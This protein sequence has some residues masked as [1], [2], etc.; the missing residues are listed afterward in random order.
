MLHRRTTRHEWLLC[1]AIMVSIV[2]GS[3]LLTAQNRSASAP[4]KPS[5]SDTA[6]STSGAQVEEEVARLRS[7]LAEL[8]EAIRVATAKTVVAAATPLPA[9]TERANPATVVST[10][11]HAEAGRKATPGAADAETLSKLGEL[12]DRGAGAGVLREL[13]KFLTAGDKGRAILY[14]VLRFLDIERNRATALTGN[15]QLAFG[16]VHIAMLHPVELAEFVHYYLVAPEGDG[17]SFMRQKMYDFIPVF[18]RFH[19]GRFPDLES[20]F[21]GDLLARLNRRS[22]DLRRLF[23]AMNRLDI[24]PPIATVERLLAGASTYL[25]RNTLMEHLA[26]RNDREA[27]A[28]LTRAIHRTSDSRGSDLA[29]ALRAL[30]TMNVAEANAA[31]G[32]YLA[33]DDVRVLTLAMT[34]YFSV[35]RDESAVRLALRFLN[36]SASL[37]D[38][39]RLVLRLRS[40]NGEILAAVA[41][42]RSELADKAV[43]DLIRR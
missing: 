8:E 18:L 31:L 12:I 2:S 28:V 38:K 37:K 5:A 27:V 20:D 41:A 36:S 43:R 14:D 9:V 30:A 1:G 3:A 11:R 23:A 4:Q 17:P 29:A 34:A 35:S 10:S 19:K 13:Q 25:D 22:K 42:R 26:A 33:S 16:L 7:R 40:S 39:R 15:Y 32:R 24:R 21:E 6:A